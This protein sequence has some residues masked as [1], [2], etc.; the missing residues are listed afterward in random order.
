MS[1]ET[2]NQSFNVEVNGVNFEIKP[3]KVT[4]GTAQGTIKFR[5]D[6]SKFSLSDF[7]NA[8]GE[9]KVL[10]EVQAKWQ[11][12]ANGISDEA[13]EESKGD[14]L[15]FQES[16]GKMFTVLSS[17]GESMKALVERRN[18]LLADLAELSGLLA[19]DPTLVGK[20]QELAQDIASIQADIEAKKH[21]DE[22]PAPAPAAAA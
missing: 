12:L 20:F 17:R 16:Y 14:H 7:I 6:F 1:E 8:W 11:S 15:K 9:S 3:N 2:V 4:K 22:E 13:E 18:Q 5:P 19:K 21:K 10:K